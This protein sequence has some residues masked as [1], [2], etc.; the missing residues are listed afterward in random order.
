MTGFIVIGAVGLAVV[1]A[2]LLLGDILDGLFDAFDLDVGGGILSAPVLGS[3]LAAFGFGAA[4]IM[5]STGVG[6]TAGALGGLA[7]GAVVG[8]LALVMMRQ[9]MDMPTDASMDT[10]DLVG[11]TGHVITPVPEGG[12]G[13]VTV[14]HLGS[15][16]KLNARSTSGPI[17]AGTAVTVTAVLSTSS[18]LVE[19][20]EASA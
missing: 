15:A 3:F 6:A 13:E 18:V 5:F 4:L 9:L 10:A 16:H 1:L 2:S 11:A 14:R 19:A 8:G 12:F 7:S 17:P 20:T